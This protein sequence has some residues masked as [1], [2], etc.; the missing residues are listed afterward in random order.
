MLRDQT[1]QEYV[2]G[3]DREVVL[4]ARATTLR[5][6]RV[7]SWTGLV[8]G[9]LILGLGVLMAV[10]LTGPMAVGPGG[11][12]MA[13]LIAVP[14]VI[15]LF[16]ERGKLARIRELNA[17]WSAHPIPPA[18]MRMS[19]QG[20]TVSIDAA[21]DHVFLPWP[22]VAGLRVRP[23]RGK[24][25][26]MVDLVP[27]APGAP[28]V[29]GLDQPD[30]RRVLDKKVMGVRGIRFAVE[31]LTRPLSEIDQ[32]AAHYTQGRVRVTGPA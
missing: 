31:T 24:R 12:L 3:L 14:G 18:A 13:A 15:L 2:V 6:L 28:G 9:A 10:L 19:A 30:V 23:F 11:L 20:L 21:A 27:G 26:L 17:A 22:A 25:L 16:N 1:S 7:S 8:G 4:A 5:L 32:A 29:R